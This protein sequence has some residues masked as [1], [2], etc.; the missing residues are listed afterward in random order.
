MS[1]SK[2]S[3]LKPGQSVLCDDGHIEKVLYD[4]IIEHENESIPEA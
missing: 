3:I 4:K 1:Y 2:L